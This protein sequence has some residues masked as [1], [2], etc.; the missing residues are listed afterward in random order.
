MARTIFSRPA[1][2][3]IHA[4]I[5]RLSPD[6]VGQWGT[7]T[8]RRMVC[9]IADQLRVAL[10]DIEARAG[11]L[12]LRF[13]DREVK[14]SPGL[15]WFHLGRRVLVH[16]LAWPKSRVGAPPEMLTTAPGEWREDVAAL[17]AL[18]DRVGGKSASETWGTHPVFGA[19][20][21]QEWG[22]LCWKHIDYHLRQFGA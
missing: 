19:I 17:H 9:H 10:G 11:R 20:S 2:A 4:R 5:D 12:R 21:G 7:M 18:V 8:A 13:G 14:V 16:W 22:L 3:A 6:D 1:R 15:L